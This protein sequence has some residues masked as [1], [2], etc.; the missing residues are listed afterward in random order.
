ML[1]FADSDEA[2]ALVETAGGTLFQDFDPDRLSKR[3]GLG[4]QRLE[5]HA[6]KAAILKP[7]GKV[8]RIE[9]EEIVARSKANAAR[10][11]VADQDESQSR[12]IEVLAKDP[13]RAFRREAADAFE[14]FARHLDAQRQ[15][16][17]EVGLTGRTEAPR[18]RH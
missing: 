8:E 12:R 3:V 10:D 6:A 17:L 11:V 1:A 2:M 5:D 9:G 18:F 14:V 13:A 16:G 15:Q 4:Q 7:A